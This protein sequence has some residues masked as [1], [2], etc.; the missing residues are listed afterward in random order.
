MMAKKGLSDSQ[1]ITLALQE[2]NQG[3]P[4]GTYASAVQQLSQPMQTPQDEPQS[5]VDAINR[6]GAPPTAPVGD[7]MNQDWTDAQAVQQM[8]DKAQADQDRRLA[9][10]FGMPAAKQN[11]MDTGNL[12][13]AVDRYIEKILAS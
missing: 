5:W 3:L 6:L 11:Q 7:A 4:A 12:P 10:V 9:Q 8:Q 13:P 1:A 2:M